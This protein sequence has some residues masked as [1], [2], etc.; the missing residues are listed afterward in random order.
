MLGR[1]PGSL[2]GLPLTDLVRASDLPA[3]E[4]GLRLLGSGAVE[5]Y[6]AERHF[7]N[8]DGTESTVNSWVRLV[9]VDGRR[10]ALATI[11]RAT[12]G[13]PWPILAEHIVIALAV[14]DHDWVIEHASSDVEKVFGVGPDLLIGSAVLGLLKPSDISLFMLA[15]ARLAHGRAAVAARMHFRNSKGQWHTVSCLLAAMC[16][17]SPPRLG[18]AIATLP[19][20]DGEVASDLQR[21]VAARGRDVLGS[22][23]RFCSWASH[24]N[25]STR[26]WEIFQRLLAGERVADIAAALYLSPSTVRNHLT[27]IYRKFGVHSHAEL[28]AVMLNPV[29]SDGVTPA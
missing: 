22:M 20:G 2:D 1:P 8:A 7:Q 16:R 29:E 14:T 27:A 23:D 25:L 12:D 4:A 17:H 9:N 11:E 5:G 19:K 15:V 18:L 3:V 26:Q 24:G 6:L 13:L 28:L 21:Q 10:L